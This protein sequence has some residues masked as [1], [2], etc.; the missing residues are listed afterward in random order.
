M[1][2]T[3][4]QFLGLASALALAACS[5][6]GG[7][8]LFQVPD[9]EAG[10]RVAIAYRSVAVREVSLPAYAALQ[11]ISVAGSDGSL[12]SAPGYLW[13]D[14]PVRSITLDL[15]RNLARLTGAQ[16]ASEP[17]PFREL[18]EISVDV[19]VEE[20]VAIRSGSLRLSGQY[21]TAPD[22]AERRGHAHFFDI[23]VPYAPD[24]GVAAI[25]AA[26]AA[27]VARLARDIAANG[28]R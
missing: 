28:L 15:T 4:R 8:A 17:W 26:R 18:P 20:L 21:F 27:A 23:S 7:P 19:R 22:D 10:A 2:M 3:R 14:D 25:A 6:G 24:G 11:E 16:V 9:V 1:T 12:I 13:A 5:G